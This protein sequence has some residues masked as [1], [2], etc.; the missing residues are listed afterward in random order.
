MERTEQDYCCQA[1]SC[2]HILL[3]LE[4]GSSLTEFQTPKRT[5][6]KC[7][8]KQMQAQRTYKRI[9]PKVVCSAS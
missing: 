9:C 5:W 7:N 2:E 3:Q 8:N 6:D 4:T 1:S